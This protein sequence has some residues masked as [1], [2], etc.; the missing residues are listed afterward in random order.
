MY[1]LYRS[2]QHKLLDRHLSCS[3]FCFISNLQ[4]SEIEVH[5]LLI[6]EEDIKLRKYLQK[7]KTEVYK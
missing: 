5:L 3:I 7:C 2:L 4:S 6:N 1:V